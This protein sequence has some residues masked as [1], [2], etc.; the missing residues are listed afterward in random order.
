MNTA[1]FAFWPFFS[2]FN[3]GGRGAK[4]FVPKYGDRM[5]SIRWVKWG[6]F[7]WVKWGGLQW[8]KWVK[9]VKVWLDLG[10]VINFALRPLRGR[11]FSVQYSTVSL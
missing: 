8:M 2:F 7:Q 4:K 1:A 10:A 11:G 6:G 9:W 5:M 3:S